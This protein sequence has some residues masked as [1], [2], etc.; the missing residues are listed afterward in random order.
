M[1]QQSPQAIDSPKRPKQP[2]QPTAINFDKLFHLKFQKTHDLPSANDFIKKSKDELQM[3]N[4]KGQMHKNLLV[5][6]KELLQGES[7][8]M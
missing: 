7:K 1:Y 5:D 8:I 4:Q 6:I 2:M 3:I